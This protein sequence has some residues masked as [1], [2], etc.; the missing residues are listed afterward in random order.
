[1]KKQYVLICKVVI[2][3]SLLV[4]VPAESFGGSRNIYGVQRKSGSR[5]I[6]GVRSGSVRSGRAYGDHGSSMRNNYFGGISNFFNK[7]KTKNKDSSTPSWEDIYTEK[8]QVNKPIK[9]GTP[10]EGMEAF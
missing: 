10:P 4:G 8:R 6:T 5:S 7:S 2:L 1:M 3:I 9:L